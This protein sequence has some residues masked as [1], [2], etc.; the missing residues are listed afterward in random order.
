M[1]PNAEWGSALWYVTEI[2]VRAEYYRL[3]LSDV[4]FVHFH[5]VRLEEIGRA[6]GAIRLLSDLGMS[7][8][9]LLDLPPRVNE[10]AVDRL[11]ADVKARA[12]AFYEEHLIEDEDC[13]MLAHYYHGNGRAWG[14]AEG[15][16]P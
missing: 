1:E 10:R 15:R 12:R 6:D 8:Q 4:P 3:L 11:S 9:R 5:D 16:P 13:R 14:T 7:P 2:F